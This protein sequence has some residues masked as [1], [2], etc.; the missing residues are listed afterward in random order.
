MWVPF[1]FVSRLTRFTFSCDIP[2]V[3]V[4]GLPAVG[5]FSVP[6][7][8]YGRYLLC[9]SEYITPGCLLYFIPHVLILYFVFSHNITYEAEKAKYT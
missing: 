5:K 8:I 2:I 4:C 3:Q 1:T 9:C 7:F 6:S